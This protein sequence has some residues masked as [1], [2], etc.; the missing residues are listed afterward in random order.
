LVLPQLDRSLALPM[1]LRWMQVRP[2]G[3]P[4]AGEYTRPA[5]LSGVDGMRRSEVQCA[6]GQLFNVHYRDL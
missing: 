1:P 2:D 6:G 4:G 5:A 3:W